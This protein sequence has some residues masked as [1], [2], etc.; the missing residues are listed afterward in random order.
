MRA[1]AAGALAAAALA[2]C[3]DQPPERAA[4][5]RIGGRVL[6]VS[7]GDTIR[8]RLASGQVER[9]RYIGVDTPETDKPSAPAECYAERARAFNERLVGDRDVMLELDVEQ[10]DRYGRLLAYVRAG[11][12]LVNAELLRA[13]Y[14]VPLVVPPNVRFER[15]FRKLG[16]AARRDGDG[17]WAACA[18]QGS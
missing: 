7:D 11:R 5:G 14:A 6:A 8:V 15:R 9:V 13:G 12:A 17:L 3:G 2:A 1:A 10:R 18:R 16:L 4:D